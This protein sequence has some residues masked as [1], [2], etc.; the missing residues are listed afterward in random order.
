[1]FFHSIAIVQ[2]TDSD[3]VSVARVMW[4]Y[5]GDVHSASGESWKAS[6]WQKLSPEASFNAIIMK[7]FLMQ[8]KLVGNNRK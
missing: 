6:P 8:I 7:I 4:M 1:M 2:S 3:S 5:K